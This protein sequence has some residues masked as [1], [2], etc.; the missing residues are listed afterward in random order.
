[1]KPLQPREFMY[2][3]GLSL[4][5]ILGL[6]RILRPSSFYRHDNLTPDQIARRDRDQ[7]WKGY[8]FA[9]FSAAAIGLILM[10]KF[11]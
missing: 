7:K 11:L 3:G 9:T 5:L 1:M 2:I 6:I 4:M 10:T 8:L